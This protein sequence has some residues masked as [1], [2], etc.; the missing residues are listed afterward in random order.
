MPKG[1]GCM[2]RKTRITE[3]EAAVKKSLMDRNMTQKELA[4]KIGIKQQYLN[5]I[6]SG[7]RPNSKYVEKIKEVLEI[8]A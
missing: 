4:E 7:K 5:L 2:R 8:S 1:G 6:F 3:F